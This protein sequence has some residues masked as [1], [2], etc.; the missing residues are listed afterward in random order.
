MPKAKDNPELKLSGADDKVEEMEF[1]P[2]QG[3]PML[4]WRGKRPYKSTRYYP[5]QLKEIYGQP[6]KGPDGKPW[7][8]RIYWGDNREVMSHLLREF[9][10]KVDLVYIDPPFDSKAEYKKAINLKNGKSARSDHSAFEEKQY[11]DIW[12]NDEYLQF[13]Y[14]RLVLIREL[15]NEN[16]SLYLHCDYNQASYLKIILDE[17]FGR[18]FFH[19]E[20]IWFYSNKYGAN[21]RT[22]DSFHN[23]LFLYSKTQSPVYNR[24]KV[25]VKEKRKQP[26]RKWNKE[27][28]KNEWQ[29]DESGN[30]LYV[31]STTK[32]LAD[33]WCKAA[34][35]TDPVRR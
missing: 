22:L 16:G 32:E 12:T 23:T 4:H 25:P 7:L 31:E 3:Y 35:N 10:G 27:L 24:I 15:L 26:L 11:T 14:E 29:K 33:V 28:G 34:C 5:A 2:I 17:I 18:E 30:Y 20:I 8:N 1:E 6:T 19:N 21:S 13:I 9:R